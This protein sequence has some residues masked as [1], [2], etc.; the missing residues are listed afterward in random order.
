MRFSIIKGAVPAVCCALL[1]ALLLAGD[2][3]YK[4]GVYKGS[5][6]GYIGQIEVEV[7]VKDSKI[8]S[9]KILKHEED[10]P[11]KALVEIPKRIVQAQSAK[12]DAVTGATY[13]SKGICKAVE[14]ALKNAKAEGGK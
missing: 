11:K 2:A 6:K 13:T 14:E 3:A 10:K 1:P 8:A 4:D 9:V 7:A 12:V 5:A